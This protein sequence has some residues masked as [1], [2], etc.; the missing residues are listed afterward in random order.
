MIIISRKIKLKLIFTFL[1]YVIS[2]F[3]V[4][5][6]LKS[7]QYKGSVCGGPG[8]N[9]ISFM[10]LGISASILMI[11]SLKL[12]FKNDKQY[13][14]LAGLNIIASLIWAKIFFLS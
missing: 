3:I 6:I 8:L 10:L 4:F 13:K 12:T 2:S 7:P 9:I 14:Y 1:F 11:K 5:K